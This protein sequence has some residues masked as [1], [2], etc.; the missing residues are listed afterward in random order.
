M[1]IKRTTTDCLPRGSGRGYTRKTLAE[2]WNEL[3][4][5]EGA[6]IGVRKGKFSAHIC[7]SI[8]GVHL[9]CIDPWMPYAHRKYRKERQDQ[10]WKITVD[11]LAQYNCTILRKTSMDA[12]KDI[13]DGQLDFVFIDGDHTFDYVMMDLICWSK[14]V[15]SGGMVAL[16]DYYHFNWSGVV[17][18]VRAYTHCHKIDPW[19][20]TKE[21]EPTAYWVQP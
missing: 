16:H 7:R 2:V 11:S 12:L 1:G 19:Y 20:V 14:K 5:K 3:G 13:K 4:Y 15:R 10:Y 21:L 6:E 9:Y 17:E 8:P 18:A